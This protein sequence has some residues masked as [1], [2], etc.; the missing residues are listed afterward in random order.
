M[1]SETTIERAPIPLAEEFF[2]DQPFFESMRELQKAITRRA[3]EL[4]EAG[5]FASGQELDHWLQAEPEFVMP[6][7]VQVTEKTDHFVYRTEVPG[8]KEKELDI[9]VEPRKLLISGT[10]KELAQKKEAE[11]KKDKIVSSEKYPPEI[12]RWFELPGEVIPEKT[13]ATLKKGVLEIVLRKAQRA[14]RIEVK[15]A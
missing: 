7:R 12:L 13:K 2:D 3:Y 4:F 8:F 14:K 6:I 10:R 11:R 5:G 15:A 1:L 9:R